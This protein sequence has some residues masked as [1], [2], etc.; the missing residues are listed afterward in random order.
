MI[1]PFLLDPARGH[2]PTLARWQ[3]APPS[4]KATVASSASAPLA[5][6]GTLGNL[7]GLK[8]Q[9]VISRDL[10]G[11]ITGIRVVT[12]DLLTALPDAAYATGEVIAN[13]YV[14][15]WDPMFSGTKFSEYC[16][17]YSKYKVH[18]AVF[19]YEPT[20]P[21]TTSGAICGAMFNDPT[22]DVANLTAGEGLRVASAQS[23]AD[24]F[25]AWSTGVFSGP[26]GPGATEW[27]FCE[28][29]GGSVRFTAAGVVGL[30]AAGDLAGTESPGNLYMLSEL[31]LSVPSLATD[32]AAGA[33]VWLKDTTS[34]TISTYQP[35]R[36][37]NEERIFLGGSDMAFVLAG[38]WTQSGTARTG[39]YV[40]GLPPGDYF[41]QLIVRG[42]TLTGSTSIVITDEG[43]ASGV[44]LTSNGIIG[45][46]NSGSVCI[47]TG[48]ISVPPSVPENTPL[49][50]LVSCAGASQ[51]SSGFVLV[52]ADEGIWASDAS[53]AAIA[54]PSVVQSQMCRVGGYYSMRR[55]QAFDLT[56]EGKQA[57]ADRRLSQLAR[58]IARLKEKGEDFSPSAYAPVSAVRAAVTRW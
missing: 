31:E 20:C 5:S 29:N 13:F 18:K 58:E 51:S 21:A 57:S 50:A 44:E 10:R 27:L 45:S 37:L 8:S 15:P 26:K 6:G 38:N 39:N 56:A 49:F 52:C 3:A 25:T 54:Q 53:P 34:T 33:G 40:A 19:I 42:G 30:V 35:L 1:I 28:S 17:L 22:V 48:F 41:C 43:A 55:R 11:N 32:V 7:V 46:A 9:R 14:A 23:G 24:T 2:A 12:M 47:S 16:Q 4:V 36:V